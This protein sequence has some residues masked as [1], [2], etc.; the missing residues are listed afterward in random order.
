MEIPGQA[1]DEGK[2]SQVE[3]IGVAGGRDLC[4]RSAKNSW[5]ATVEC[6]GGR[7]VSRVERKMRTCDV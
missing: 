7:K 2:V 3:G 5:P 6:T 1:R 4:H